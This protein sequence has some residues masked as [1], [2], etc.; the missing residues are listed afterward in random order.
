VSPR[1][2]AALSA[3]AAGLLTERTVSIVRRALEARAGDSDQWRRQNYRGRDVSLLLGPA[4]AA[5]GILGVALAARGSRSAAVL[6][7]ASA[8]GVGLYDDLYGDRHAKGLAGHARALRAG[9]VTTGMVKL[10][11]LAS[12][13]AAASAIR[14]RDPVDI[15]LGTVLV[16]GGANLVNLFDLR[17]G[18][19]AKVTS[20]AALLLTRADT[21]ET[22]TVA[23]VAAG[24]AAAALPVDLAE[25]AMLGDCGAGTLGALLGWAAGGS[26]SRRRRV[27]L[28][29]GV[30]GLTALSERVSF[31]AV[32]A[33][34][35]ALRRLDQFGRQTA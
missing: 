11:G 20:L 18:R 3:P 19:A 28:A 23:A 33:G 5:G 29:A 25:Q 6:A 21:R 14:Y 4:T 7:V 9:R 13:A 10:V 26:G 8:A 32:I 34:H 1:R 2:F 27:V 12:S 16:A 24:A 31:S 35:P 30:V 15:A 22:R 17:P